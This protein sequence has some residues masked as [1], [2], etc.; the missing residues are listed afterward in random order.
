MVDK[1]YIIVKIH[2]W[3]YGEARKLVVH[4]T[5]RQ[6]WTNRDVRG[7]ANVFAPTNKGA[8][9]RGTMTTCVAADTTRAAVGVGSAQTSILVAADTTRAAVGVGSARIDDRSQPVLP[10]PRC[11][12]GRQV[13][14]LLTLELRVS[15][16]SSG[17]FLSE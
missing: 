7:R 6:G 5:R 4:T 17:S 16:G 13:G 15:V 10:I 8:T 11:P 1:E 9:T 14:E 3:S 2:V 12:Q